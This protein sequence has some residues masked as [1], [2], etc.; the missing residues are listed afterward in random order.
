MRGEDRADYEWM[1]RAAFPR[2]HRTVFLVLRDYGRAE[3][4]TQEALLKLLQNWGKVSS[5]EQPEAWVRRVAIRLAVRQAGREGG[6][7]AR[8]VAA[9][10][11]MSGEEPEGDPAVAAAVAALAPRQRAAVVLHYYEDLP[12]LEVARI[13]NVSESTVK[14]HLL[15]ARVRLAELLGEEVPHGG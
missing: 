3:E 1:F 14:Q 11:P 12:V 10:R 8:E 15:R 6:R 13:L 4:V 5:Y 7:V 2:I 9:D